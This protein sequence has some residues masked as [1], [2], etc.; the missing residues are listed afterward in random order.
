MKRSAIFLFLAIFLIGTVARVEASQD[1]H[2]APSKEKSKWTRFK[3]GA[4]KE[5]DIR[6]KMGS[7]SK[8]MRVGEDI[9]YVYTG[10]HLYFRNCQEFHSI[11]DPRSVSLFFFN[12]EIEKRLLRVVSSDKVKGGAYRQFCGVPIQNEIQINRILKKYNKK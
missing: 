10:T 6:L 4:S 1:I 9:V 7:P 11:S 12:R 2:L 8:I 5:N 3:I